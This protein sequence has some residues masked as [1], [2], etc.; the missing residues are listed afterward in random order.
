MYCSREI[1]LNGYDHS[2][3]C[4]SKSSVR[5]F[6]V[7]WIKKEQTEYIISF[8]VM[9]CTLQCITFSNVPKID[10]IIHSQPNQTKYGNNATE[11]CLAIFACVLRC[12]TFCLPDFFLTTYSLL[13]FFL[14]HVKR[15]IIILRKEE[16]KK[17]QRW[18]CEFSAPLCDYVIAGKTQ[19][20]IHKLLRMKAY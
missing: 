15:F 12:T 16:E 13:I 2:E 14:F 5:F 3:N 4:V 9:H 19:V 18:L 10:V 20:I 6:C 1:I 11:D 7:A 8:I 17:Q